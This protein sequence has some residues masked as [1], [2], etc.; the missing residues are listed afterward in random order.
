MT[1]ATEMNALVEKAE[2]LL[3][4]LPY[5]QKFNRKIMIIKYGG[6][7]MENPLMQQ[8]VMEDI[9]LLKIVGFKPI[10]VH[11]G[12]KEISAWSKLLNLET[13]FV[14]GLRVTDSKTLEIAEMVLGKVNQDL[15]TLLSKLGVK[16]I[17]VSGKDGNL[18]MAE[19]K[20]KDGK[21]I[22]FVGKI[23]SVNSKVL[24]DLLDNDY[25]PVVF[26]I[27]I[28]EKGQGYNINGD[29]A[30]CAIAQ[31]MGAEKLAFLT[32]TN[33][34]YEDKDDPTTLISE[35]YVN[36]AKNLIEKGIINGGMVPKI[37]NSIEAIENGVSRVH[38]LDGTI[39]HAMLLE[40][41][42]DRG[43]GTAILNSQEERFYHE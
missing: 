26:P 24:H 25:L 10:L 42:T 5:I 30:A 23:K 15:V 36:D 19:K 17:G 11:G 16:A 12:G 37:L 33:G 27:G 20:E 18:I 13:K 43:V 38:I 31:A 34:V 8:K 9:V 32:D 6:S 35:L 14:D 39:P 21:D 40:F 28:D 1:S 29:D 7:A 41:F 3:E 4:A 22:G 2:V